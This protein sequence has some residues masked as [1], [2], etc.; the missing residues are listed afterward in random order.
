MKEAGA[1][2]VSEVAELLQDRHL[3]MTAMQ[4]LETMGEGAVGGIVQ[5]VKCLQDEDV[6]IRRYAISTLRAMGKAAASQAGAMASLEESEAP[7]L[8]NM[9]AL[10]RDSDASVRAEA[11]WTLS[12][13]E[14]WEHAA[15]VAQLLEDPYQG[16]RDAAR[17]VILSWCGLES[18]MVKHLKGYPYLEFLGGQAVASAHGC[19]CPSTDFNR[20]L[21]T[22]VGGVPTQKRPRIQ[23]QEQ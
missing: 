23:R 1:A 8:H 11:L 7:P 10:L 15:E 6:D 22:C 17:D 21:R 19:L 18:T 13:M 4:A 14:A 20:S 9:I 5:V 16:V 12:A 2:H 3:G